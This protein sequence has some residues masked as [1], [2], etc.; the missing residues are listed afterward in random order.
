[1]VRVAAIDLG[2]NSTRLLVADVEDG[3]LDEVARRLTIT[4][5]GEG[6]DE[7]RR[8]LPVPIARVRSCLAE[9]RRELEAL[10]ATRTLAVATS[11]VR[12]AENG[13]AFLGEI[14]WSYG[15]TTRLLSGEEEAALT[16]RGVAAG[17]PSVEGTLIVDIGGGSTELV[18]GGA[19][20]PAASSSVDV[21]CVRVTE[22]FL[23]SDPP[24]REELAAAAAYVRSLLPP[25]E[26][27]SAIGVAGTVT[28]L[29]TLDL[30]LAEYDPQRTH[31]HRIPRASVERELE[32]LAAL[33]SAERER[34]PGIEP[35]RAPVIVAGLVVLREVLDAYGLPEIEVS[36][37]DLLHGAALAA[38]ELPEPE[39]GDAPPGAYTC[40]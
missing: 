7:R 20:G 13:E 3:R 27:R 22:R 10:G 14:E 19:D 16:L 4:R 25:L 28:T 5:L 11:A 23:A 38:A 8:L 21:G 24:S 33:T 32:R 40:C 17:R 37:R 6:V 31:G 2:T 39:E 18:L 29:A 9:Y 12:D 1:M 26:A 30:G 15:F 34:V 36:E 35:G